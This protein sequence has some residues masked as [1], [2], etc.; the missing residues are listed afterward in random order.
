MYSKQRGG[1]G[2]TGKKAHREK[3]VFDNHAVKKEKK[4]Y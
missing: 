3:K 2:V 1:V 4:S